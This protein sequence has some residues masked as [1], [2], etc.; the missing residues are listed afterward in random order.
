MLEFGFVIGPAKNREAS[1]NNLEKIG[2]WK[3][4]LFDLSQSKNAS[5]N[6]KSGK[7][8]APEFASGGFSPFAGSRE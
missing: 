4:N 6:A 7:R 3:A 1:K 2:S 5:A 8:R